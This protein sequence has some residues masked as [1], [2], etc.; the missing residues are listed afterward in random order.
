MPPQALAGPWG[1][2]HMRPQNTQI[3][4]ITMTISTKARI[5]IVRVFM[6]PPETSEMIGHIVDPFRKA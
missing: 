1:T 3:A 4:K 5:A 6:C 2:H